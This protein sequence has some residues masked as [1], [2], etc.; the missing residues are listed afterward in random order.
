[1][2]KKLLISATVATGLL[3]GLAPAA[4]AGIITDAVVGHDIHKAVEHHDQHQQQQ[5]AP[6]APQR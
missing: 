6:P 3:M 4:N 1:M 5:P 2:K